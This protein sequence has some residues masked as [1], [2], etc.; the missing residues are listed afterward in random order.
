MK[1]FPTA[2]IQWLE[3]EDSIT[4][5]TISG[6]NSDTLTNNLNRNW[7]SKYFKR[8]VTF[9]SCISTSN[10]YHYRV[11][12]KPLQEIKFCD[13]FS[14]PFTLSYK[15]K[16]DFLITLQ[17]KHKGLG[18][19]YWVNYMDQ[20][21]LKNQFIVSQNPFDSIKVTDSF[22]YLITPIGCQD[23]INSMYS[24]IEVPT[25]QDS[26]LLLIQ[27]VNKTINY[28]ETAG[29]K[30][31]VN[32]PNK[33]K[34]TWQ[35]SMSQNGPW[36]NV[37][38]SNF[39]S[40][41][42][43]SNSCGDSM[44]VRVKIEH[45]CTTLFSDTVKFIIN[46]YSILQSDYWMKDD[47]HDRGKEPNNITTSFVVSED[48]WIRNYNDGKLQHQELNTM[49]D[50]NWVNVTIRN[51]QNNPISGAKL[52]L[53]WTWG[54]TSETWTRN[55]TKNDS[56]Y[57]KKGNNDSF[58]MGSEIN[59]VDIDLPPISRNQIYKVV[60]P[61][62]NFPRE[63][64]Y[65]L[66]NTF[67]T[68]KINVCLLARIITCNNAPYGMTFAEG[69]DVIKNIKNNN[70]IISRNIWTREFQV[71]NDENDNKYK[72]N[73][74]VKFNPN[75]ND[76]GVILVGSTSD[77]STTNDVCVDTEDSLF[78]TKAEA[79]VKLPQNLY[80]IWKTSS[81]SLTGMLYVKDNCFK[82]TNN[83]ACLKAV[84]FPTNDLY[85]VAYYYGYTDVNNRFTNNE[86]FKVSI[87][88]KDENDEVIGECIYMIRDN[89][90]VNVYKEIIETNTTYSI[91]YWEEDSSYN[92][93]IIY[94]VSHS[95]PYKIYKDGNEI[96]VNPY[97]QYG[98]KEGEYMVVATDNVNNIEYIDN[99]YVMNDGISENETTTPIV[100]PCDSPYYEYETFDNSHI[101]YDLYNNIQTPTSGNTYLLD[102]T[103]TIYY[104]IKNNYN[105][106]TVDKIKIAFDDIPVFPST[107]TANLMAQYNLELDTCCFIKVNDLN[108]YG[109]PLAQGQNLDVYDM[110]LN[111]Q[112]T[113][114][115]QT[116]SDT[117][118][119]FRFCPPQ[120]DTTAENINDQYKMV[121]KSS[122]CEYCRIDFAC[123]N[124]VIF[125]NAT[126][127]SDIKIND[128]HIYPNPAQNS[129]NVFIKNKMS[130][131]HV[132]V[133]DQLGKQVMNQEIKD[134][135]FSTLNVS[136]LVSG[137]YTIFIPELNYNYKLVLI[138]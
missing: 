138:K 135:N 134:S 69:K 63:G 118:M 1:Y 50:T 37:L 14:F 76:G 54:S 97:H 124:R 121:Y 70:N 120:W 83:H 113:V 44:Y 26:F 49:L 67:N 58:L 90:F 126:N 28:G 5:T 66:S 31:K 72:D 111:Y 73:E 23:F 33:C 3:S 114:T 96:A 6:A 98:F 2:T 75:L 103:N 18:S 87:N 57:I 61:W 27:P 77:D 71:P 88:Q 81:N 82:I 39:D 10:I 51:R 117:T 38:N 47:R 104:D 122:T 56:N 62:T 112:F 16:A 93:S 110:A 127:V 65:D 29:F 107:P 105:V 119:G 17:Y 128:I 130:L 43:F 79:Y 19:Q 11:L 22:R 78:F 89:P 53:Y 74:I 108:C 7:F 25:K 137:V 55:W 24:N 41:T 132:I 133:Y 125:E 40:I 101:V 52:R 92:D 42:L 129:V 100:F 80:E 32:N 106:C 102:G 34:F 9:G 13:S 60:Y 68:E 30:V 36:S 99:V 131:A 123:D 35:T 21:H 48:I 109:M 136:E 45:A 12:D 115:I 94:N 59:F 85:P 95:L 15:I 84:N 91:C 86:V 116:Y 20:N 4:W 46:N 64:W 8:V